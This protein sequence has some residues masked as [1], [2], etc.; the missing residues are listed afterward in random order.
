MRGLVAAL[1]IS[2]ATS[3]W[4]EAPVARRILGLYDSANEQTVRYSALHQLAEM[5]L[6][7]L[8]LML[9]HVDVR[10]GLPPVETLGPDV[11]G[12]VIWF[13]ANHSP[14]PRGLIDWGEKFIDSG[15]KLVIMGESG[16]TMDC[17]GRPVPLGRK[18]KLLARLGLRAEG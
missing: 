17:Q 10:Q 3:A 16:L 6:N 14:D 15:R 13:V 18:N 4:A 11:R 2:A 7:W 8:G 12:A 1:A 9:D 5:P